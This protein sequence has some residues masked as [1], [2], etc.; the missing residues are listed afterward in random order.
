LAKGHK[1]SGV[2]VAGRINLVAESTLTKIP[3]IIKNQAVNLQTNAGNMRQRQFIFLVVCLLMFCGKFFGQKFPQ[4]NLHVHPNY[5]Y[6]GLKI[7]KQGS[8]DYNNNPAIYRF[9][10]QHYAQL[11][12]QREFLN[13][14]PANFYTRCL[15]I[16]CT[17][18]FKLEKATG[19]PFRIRL[20][21]V[22]YVN[23]L[24]QKPNSSYKR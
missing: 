9:T 22:E 1:L 10:I 24:E 6:V 2:F 19:V 13:V 14:L 23:H 18:E 3:P 17:N 8:S 20:G 15:G 16:I 4:K 12:W 7:E 5:Q 21:S 11:N